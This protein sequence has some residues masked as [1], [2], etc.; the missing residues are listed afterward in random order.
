[1]IAYL[2][3][4]IF[5]KDLRYVI[6]DTGNVGYKVTTTIDVLNSVSLH[7]KTSLWIYTAVRE[8]AL[9]L[10]GFPNKESLDFF[11]LLISISGIGPKSAIGILGVA[12]IQS[13]KEA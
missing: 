12:T 11:E 2:T 9:D 8:D 13:L 10:Y 5:H 6:V 4:T 3:G 1:M 7:D